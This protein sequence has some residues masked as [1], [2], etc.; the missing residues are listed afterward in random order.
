MI[1]RRTNGFYIAKGFVPVRHLSS[2]NP[3]D[4]GQGNIQAWIVETEPEILQS[5]WSAAQAVEEQAGPLTQG[6]L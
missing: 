6:E 1:R 3:D 5:A 2:K 4:M